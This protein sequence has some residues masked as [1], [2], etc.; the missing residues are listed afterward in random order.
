VA[1]W[2]NSAAAAHDGDVIVLGINGFAGADH[3]AAAAVVVDGRVVAAVEEERLNRRRHAPGDQ[4]VTAVPEVLRVAGVKAGDIDVVCH[5]WRPDALG[6]DVDERSEAAT[7]RATLAGSGVELPAATPVTF[8]DHH[9]AHFFSAVP[10]LPAGADR[11]AIDGLVIDGA[12]EST[13]GAFFR[14][15]GDHTDKRWN[16]G[17]AGSLGLLYEAASAVIGFRPGEEGKTMGLA[18]YGRA[19]TMDTPPAPP[20][21]RFAGP[22]PLLSDRDSLRR[23]HRTRI[24]RLATSLARGASFNQ[25]ADFALG[26][27]S[28]VE[29]R[30]MGYL[31]EIADPAPTL[32]MAGGVALNCTINAVVAGWCRERGITLT[33]P[34]PAN[35]GGIAIGAA[36]AA[37]A[38]PIACTADNA[39]LGRG[40]SRDE[41]LAQLSAL[42]VTAGEMGADEVAQAIV[43]RDLVCGWFEGRAEIGPRALG[44]R[45]VLARVDSTRVRD[46][47]NV[48]KGR[49]SWRPLA[50][51]LSAEEFAAAFLGEPSPHMLIAAQARPSAARPMAGVIHV[52]NTARP[53]V[54]DGDPALA[55]YA[56]LLQAIR[57][58]SGR[59]AI[60]CTSFNPA[61]APIV[62]TPRDA[63]HAAVTMGLD[64]L[65]GDGWGVRLARP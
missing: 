34:P 38:D 8:V 3:D 54:V 7:I 29:S 47:L 28:L 48:M 16:L 25:R 14:T 56:D 22:I 55:P 50:P 40:Y 30:I 61:G 60:T 51:S 19:E 65:A 46:R 52:D 4:P 26:V 10:F 13:S 62:Y 20:D 1:R 35:D 33:I 23:D 17:I 64:L 58:A 39:F 27:Q 43:E 15:R 63:Y 53:Q 31:A 59:A 12:G 49:E 24:A 37:S 5:G 41:I 11:R 42:G 2:R 21:D 6:L 36:V 18:A 9:L 44:K 57:R 32:V 45:A